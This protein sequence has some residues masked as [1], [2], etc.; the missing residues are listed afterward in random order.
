MLNALLQFFPLLK[1]IALRGNFLAQWEVAKSYR[2]GIGTPCSEKDACYFYELAAQR[3]DLE[4]QEEMIKCSFF[5]I[6]VDH[7]LKKSLAYWD[8]QSRKHALHDTAFKKSLS[9][10]K[11]ASLKKFFKFSRY[12]LTGEILP[13]N[14]SSRGF[15][16]PMTRGL[17]F[18][19]NRRS[20]TT[21]YQPHKEGPKPKKQ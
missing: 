17:I 2:L 1:D 18:L 6:G 19:L 9:E 16:L 5:G 13:L 10:G 4:S 11:T 7:A 3:G 20:I 8:E 12:M 14:T 21:Y 15:T